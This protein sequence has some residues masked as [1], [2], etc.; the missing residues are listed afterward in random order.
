MMLIKNHYDKYAKDGILTL[1]SD[2]HEL[3]DYTGLST[4]TITRAFKKLKENKLI[5][6]K[7]GK[8]TRNVCASKECGY[9]E[10]TE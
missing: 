9:S 7:K 10:K 6:E 2:R 8:I 5:V 1:S 3:S 4:K